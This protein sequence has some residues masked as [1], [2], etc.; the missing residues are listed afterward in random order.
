MKRLL[1]L[2]ALALTLTA[3]PSR[4]AQSIPDALGIPHLSVSGLTV[5]A[6]NPTKTALT[7][8]TS[9]G[10]GPA[11]TVDGEHIKPGPDAKCKPGE[12]IKVGV[13]WACSVPSVAAGGTADLVFVEDGTGTG[14]IR[15]AQG[16]GYLG[17]AATV[18]LLRLR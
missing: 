8:D 12:K 6:H 5:T 4:P 3:C 18:P 10:E 15:Q 11:I 13:S 17:N 9:R 1:M 14:L 16:L 2:P 7:G